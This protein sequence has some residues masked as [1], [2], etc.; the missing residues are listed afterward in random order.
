VKKEYNFTGAVRGKF[1]H[2]HAKFNL[3]IYLDGKNREFVAAIARKKKADISVVVNELIRGDI[4]LA[5][6]LR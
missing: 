5:K 6:A 3:P 4:E 1:Y 2:P